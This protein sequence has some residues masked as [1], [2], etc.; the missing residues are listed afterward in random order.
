MTDQPQ[1]QPEIVK[2]PAQ[3]ILSVD[4][5]DEICEY[6]VGMNVPNAH[7]NRYDTSVP[8][9][10]V[11]EK[12]KVLDIEKHL[13]NP[14]RIRKHVKF[15]DADSFIAYVNEFKVGYKPQMFVMQ[16]KDGLSIQCVFDY[17]IAGKIVPQ[18]EGK[19]DAH[20]LG[21]PMWN[22]H[23]AQLDLTYSLDYAEL[24]S[25]NAEWFDQEDFALFVEENTH[26][27]I[28]PDG[29]F[30][31]ELAQDLKVKIE[32]SFR[33]SRRIANGQ[34]A[35]SYVET[36]NGTSQQSGEEVIVPTVLEMRCS[37]FEG[38]P[39][40]DIKA[41]FR[42]KKSGQSAEFQYKLMTKLQERAAHDAVRAKVS[43]ETE[44]NT[45]SVSSF[46]LTQNR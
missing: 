9:M 26:L 4:K 5:I 41:A 34:V 36:V 8:F 44:I 20:Q 13:P 46:S 10:V 29:S 14:A 1:V 43:G 17:D 27:F 7:R 32:A 16:T 38:L 11:P 15:T 25:K 35:L 28:K 30:M 6:V 18:G 31:Y 23:I 12:M 33:S 45:L 42:F 2:Q 39:A 22:S 3:V 37:I 21:L 24:R 40:E 19:P